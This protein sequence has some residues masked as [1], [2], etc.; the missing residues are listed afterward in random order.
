MLFRSCGVAVTK[1]GRWIVRLDGEK[2]TA[3]HWDDVSTRGSSAQCEPFQTIGEH[4]LVAR[5][6]PKPTDLAKIDEPGPPAKWGYTSVASIM[7][8]IRQRRQDAEEASYSGLTAMKASLRNP[9]T[10]EITER[11]FGPNGAICGYVNG[12]NG[13]G[14]MTGPQRFVAQGPTFTL[15][16]QVGTAAMNR[17]WLQNCP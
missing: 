16:E 1:W 12:E 8:D 3:E 10:A 6:T 11:R 14:G 15:E 7:G 9:K 13:F 2:M 5:R 17:I 4:D